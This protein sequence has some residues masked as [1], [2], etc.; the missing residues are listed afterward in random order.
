MGE[1]VEFAE[2]PALALGR[3]F[4]APMATFRQESCPRKSLYP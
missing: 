4:L 1:V 2:A 3:Y